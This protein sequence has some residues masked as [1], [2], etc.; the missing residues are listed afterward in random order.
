MSE[1][2][3]YQD[4]WVVFV[5]VAIFGFLTLSY[6]HNNRKAAYE[7][8]QVKPELDWRFNKP[9]LGP[10]TLDV[11]VW[12]QRPEVLQNALVTVF[13]STDKKEWKDETK[14]LVTW[15]PNRDHQVS[16]SFPLTK[17]H[18][19]NPVY[20]QVYTGGPQR[21]LYFVAL[22]WENGRWDADWSAMGREPPPP[23]QSP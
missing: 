6:W 4:G 22:K 3:W 2:H 12:H 14:S 17:S 23:K 13:V 11:D 10:T 9:L 16:F 19:D 15:S 8:S 18:T 1:K 7:A 20:F 21:K 5:I